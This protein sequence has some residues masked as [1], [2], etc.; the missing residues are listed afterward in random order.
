MGNNQIPVSR[1]NANC[2]PSLATTLKPPVQ[3]GVDPSHPAKSLTWWEI[4]YTRPLVLSAICQQDVNS[5]SLKFCKLQAGASTDQTRFPSTSHRLDWD[6]T[7][8]M[9]HPELFAMFLKFLK[10]VSLWHP[11]PCCCLTTCHSLDP[12]VPS[13]FSLCQN[14]WDLY[15]FPASNTSNKIGLIHLSVVWMLWLICT[16]QLG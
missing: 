4:N 11:W 6:L 8:P 1:S 2:W 14:Q 16:W 15:A 13:K 5:I 12:T 9:Q 10:S 7:R 3:Y